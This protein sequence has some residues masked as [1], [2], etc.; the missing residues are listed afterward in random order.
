MTYCWHSVTCVST[1]VDTWAGSS[2]GTVTLRPG[3]FP[4]QEKCQLG[5][6]VLCFISDERTMMIIPQS[7]YLCF[8]KH[9]FLLNFYMSVAG[10]II[11]TGS[12]REVGVTDATTMMMTMMMTM[13]SGNK[14]LISQLLF[15]TCDWWYSDVKEYSCASQVCHPPVMRTLNNNS[16]FSH[17]QV[18]H[19]T[20]NTTF[21]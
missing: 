8:C 18:A 17:L 5:N 19:Q 4:G 11:T 15:F 13:V 3:G 16:F 12:V 10:W 6:D 21:P 9:F 7:Q 20:V 2:H 14:S 1:R